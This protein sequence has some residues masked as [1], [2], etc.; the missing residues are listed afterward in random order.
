MMDSKVFE[1]GRDEKR[2]TGHEEAKAVMND[3]RKPQEKIIQTEDAK[4]VI[5]ISLFV[6]NAYL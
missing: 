6:D 4:L 2:R 3:R 5:E 1:K